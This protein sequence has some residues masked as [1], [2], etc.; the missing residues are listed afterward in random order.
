MKA[1][2][3][4]S[5]TGKEWR[6]FEH[7]GAKALYMRQLYGISDLQA[8]VALMRGIGPEDY[9]QY[10]DPTLRDLMP[11]PYVLKDMR[12]ATEHVAGAVEEGRA[13]GVIGDYDVDGATSSAVLALVFR[14]IGTQCEVFIPDRAE[15]GY[16]PCNRAFDRFLALGIR[17]ALTVD[18]GATA[19][20]P[21]AYAESLGI[22]TVVLDH[23]A[24]AESLPPARAV[25]NP[26]RQ[27]ET[28]A[29]GYLAAVGVTFLFAVA[30]CRELRLRGYFAA[31]AIP[32]PDL[33][34]LLDVAALGTVC[35]VVPLVGLNRAFVRQGLKIMARRGNVGLSALIDVA[36]VKDAPD[37]YHLGF[38][39][40]P[41][42]NAG[43]RV[44]DSGLG[45]ALLT[46]QDSLEAA[47]IAQRLHAYNEERKALEKLA[48]EE[49]ESQIDAGDVAAPMLFAAS[50]DWHEGVIGIVAGRLKDKYHRPVAVLSL[51]DG[52]AKAS[53]RSIEGANVGAAILAAKDA[54]LLIAGGGHA[55]AG[56]FSVREADMDAL[57]SFLRDFLKQ[58]VERNAVPV[59]TP[60][61][62][63]ALAG[64][65]LKTAEELEA[66]APYGA[67]NPK[68][69]FVFS[70]ARILSVDILGG[71]HYRCLLRDAHR[72][73]GGCVKAMAF[74]ADGSALGD[75]LR[76]CVGKVVAVAG[77]LNVNRWKGAATIDVHIDDVA[78]QETFE[79]CR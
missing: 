59:F 42:I 72:D 35:D 15:D 61:A 28:G 70:G 52:V 23:H 1:L 66:C 46:S 18:C 5:L 39:L 74:R 31:K 79:A 25:V 68:P 62:V 14:A 64:V 60:D 40:G 49:A 32:E 4:T 10:A 34:S 41:R 78:L 13:V 17:D 7:D 16:G 26:N 57:A 65:D 75:A 2:R 22:R 45:V 36:G 63:A 50:R 20:A 67:A 33:R 3:L 37:A 69:R 58:A 48:L 19:F 51:K 76:A 56:G 71:A 73:K 24:G 29:Y 9:R 30:L 43:G 53:A 38:V 27:D 21:L 12:A 11:D 54:G 47:S 77:T 44:G 6:F 55:M 8:R